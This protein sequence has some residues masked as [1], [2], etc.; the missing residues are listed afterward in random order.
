MKKAGEG[1]NK[2]DCDC[3]GSLQNCGG[4]CRTLCPAT[5]NSKCYGSGN[6]VN[7]LSELEWPALYI[8]IKCQRK[9]ADTFVIY[10]IIS[11]CASV[12]LVFAPHCQGIA[13]IG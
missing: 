2:G 10:N 12:T 1:E 4:V 11:A 9:L 13:G 7:G 5:R 3:A 6:V 8:I